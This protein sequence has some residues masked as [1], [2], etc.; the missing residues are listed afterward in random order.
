MEILKNWINENRRKSVII[1]VA[2]LLVVVCC[3]VG[4][5]YAMGN[6]EGP[7]EEGITADE[8]LDPPLI[9]LYGE[10][11]YTGVNTPVSLQAK[12]VE[13]IFAEAGLEDVTV[14]PEDETPGSEHHHCRGRKRQRS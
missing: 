7:S 11:V 5:A 12:V 13:S 1:I 9:S 8:T 14:E 10:K 6:D 4:V 3:I 2:A